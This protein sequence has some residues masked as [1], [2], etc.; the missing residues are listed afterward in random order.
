MD[1]SRGRVSGVGTEAAASPIR[2]PWWGRGGGL[3]V[4]P[5]C[6][7]S[8]LKLPRWPGPK[9]ARRGR[10]APKDSLGSG[11]SSSITWST[12]RCAPRSCRGAPSLSSAPRFPGEEWEPSNVRTNP[13]LA[14]AGP[15]SPETIKPQ[16]RVRATGERTGQE[17]TCTP[18]PRDVRAATWPSGTGK[19]PQAAASDLR[20][21]SGLGDAGRAGSG[22][23]QPPMDNDPCPDPPVP[24]PGDGAKE[25]SAGL[26]RF[27]PRGPPLSLGPGPC[28]TSAASARPAP[29]RP[30]KAPRPPSPSRRAPP[31]REP[32]PPRQP[33]PDQ[34]PQAPDG[35][36]PAGYQRR[37]NMTK[38]AALWMPCAN[39]SAVYRC[40]ACGSCPSHL[41]PRGSRPPPPPP[42][43]PGPGRPPPAAGTIS[44]GS[45][46]SSG[47]GGSGM[48]RGGQAAAGGG[49][50]RARASQRAG[51]ALAP[52][53]GPHTC[54]PPHPAAR[55]P[56]PPRRPRPEPALRRAPASPARTGPRA[57]ASSLGA[58]GRVGRTPPVSQRL[59]HLGAGGTA[60]ANR[61]GALP[62]Q[63]PLEARSGVG[64][65][66][67][68]EVRE[69]GPGG[70]RG[71]C[72]PRFHLNKGERKSELPSA[73]FRKLSR[74]K[75][76]FTPE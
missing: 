44:S 29:R 71:R 66:P 42:P 22:L 35:Q 51:R 54:R 10:R 37:E 24:G 16:A 21:S 17:V 45:S 62:L 31:E 26:F 4:Q 58:R 65:R 27:G 56:A 61:A 60:W 6:A 57:R 49:V 33:R 12:A 20:I 52:A 63:A 7:F 68:L 59:P 13:S 47:G 1:D 64:L 32:A 53:A 48:A 67:G 55:G 9:K 74:S 15:G 34:R 36:R 8:H 2:E 19:E 3:S 5:L 28:A 18:G 46:N 75:A 73:E 39:M 43:A 14:N 25:Q 50:R 23:Q 41:R 38:C 69:A 30:Q 70:H 11:V 76:R 72:R 40:L